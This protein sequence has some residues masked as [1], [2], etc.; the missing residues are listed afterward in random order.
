M[1]LALTQN[2]TAIV[3]NSDFAQFVA[4][5]GTSPYAYTVL[6]NGAGGFIDPDSGNYFAPTSMTA[7]PATQLYDT[8]QVTDASS[9]T[10]TAQILVGTPLFLFCDI[11]QTQMGLDNNHCYLWD[12]K[13]FQPI[14]SALYAIVSVPMTKPFGNSNRP[15]NGDGSQADQYV[16]MYAKVDID[17]ISR[18]PAARDQ[19]ELVVLAL[20][21]I[22]SQQ[23]QEANGFYIGK[24][25]ISGGFVN[26]SSIDGAAIPYRYKISYAIQY[27]VNLINSVPYYDS[28]QPP[29]VY[30]NP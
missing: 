3:P 18:S 1:S 10:A 28:F 29:Q 9:L 8:I 24:L 14:D 5:G 7:Y 16:A 23:Q 2:Y 17:I 4:T 15:L 12:Q 25:P 22:Y 19:K 20:N 21:S 27:Q 26:L 30:V 6:P 11:L 13:I